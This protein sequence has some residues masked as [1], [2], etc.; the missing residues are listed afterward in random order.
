MEQI[1]KHTEKYGGGGYPSLSMRFHV[2]KP[3]TRT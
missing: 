2:T 3:R 1:S